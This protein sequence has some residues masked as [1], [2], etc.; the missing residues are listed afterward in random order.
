M[1]RDVAHASGGTA[2][3]GSA[4]PTPLFLAYVTS[5]AL[6][7]VVAFRH[8]FA[9]GAVADF[10]LLAGSVTAGALALFVVALVWSA[11]ARQRAT[12][13][14]RSRAGAVV[15][16]ATRADGLERAVRALPA[17]GPLVPLGMTL[18]ADETGVE[19]W[20][21]SAERPLRLGRVPWEA[22]SDIRVAR[23]TRCGRA[24]GGIT[25][26]VSDGRTRVELPFGVLGSG[27]GGLASPSGAQLERMA[28]ALRTRRSAS[29]GA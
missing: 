17:D 25:V 20:C 4:A 12:E 5:L 21:G 26:I 16:R 18:L 6:A 3:D 14:E 9:A 24:T 1:Q 13:L 11:R 10:V 19:V 15:V 23:I 2:D 27:L 29:I 28:D 22:V 7:A 8:G